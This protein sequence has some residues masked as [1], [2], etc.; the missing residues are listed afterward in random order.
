M[1]DP[2]PLPEP[3]RT[4]FERSDDSGVWTAQHVAYYTAEQMRAYGEACR[5]A[6]LIEAADWLLSEANAQKA[7]ALSTVLAAK[8]AALRERAK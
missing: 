8:A 7:W 6:A 1:A 2:L 4:F 3:R 5:R